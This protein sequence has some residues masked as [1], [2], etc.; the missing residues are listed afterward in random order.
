ML[1][2]TNSMVLMI[3]VQEKLVK[4]TGADIEAQNAAKMIA[5]ANILGLPVLV[6]EQY[7]KGLGST[8]A[9]VSE[10]FSENTKV[11]EKSAFS[12]LKEENAL[13]TI[14]SYGKKQVILFG[15]ET[16]ICVLQT[17]LELIKNGFEV[18]L[19]KNASKSRQEFEHLSGIDVMKSAGVNVVTLEITL[20]E[21]LETSKN[22]SFKQVQAL[23]K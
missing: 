13:E 19:I 17:A 7:P 18:Y 15:I 10:N 23:I 22:P 6:S 12:I 21:L 1:N 14:K 16:H 9:N 8:V 20:F 11:I 4:A 3:D 2:T 5:A